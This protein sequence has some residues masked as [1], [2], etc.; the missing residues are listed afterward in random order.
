[1]SIV[2]I[3][4][5]VSTVKHEDRSGKTQHFQIQTRFIDLDCADTLYHPTYFL[6][7]TPAALYF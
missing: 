7:L 5:D 2:Y 1:M 3:V 6:M 4:T